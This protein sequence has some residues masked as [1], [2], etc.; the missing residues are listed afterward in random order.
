MQHLFIRKPV[1][2][3]LAL[4]LLS[5][6][7]QSTFAV[8]TQS[9]ATISNTATVDYQVGT[10]PRS[11]TGA[12][13]DILVDNRVDMTV[14][15]TDA[16]NN[17]NVNPGQ[18]DRVLTFT[19]TNTGNT[20]QGYLLSVDVPS[21]AIPMGNIRIYV[22]ANNDGIPDAGELYTAGTN[23]GDL[24]PN[25]VLGTD[26]VMQVLVVAD[27]PAGALD[28]AVDDVRL[29]AQATN[30]GTATATTA[31][32]TPTA[33]VDVVFADAAGT[34]SDANRDG[35]HSAAASYTVLSAALTAAK[36][37]LSTTDEFGSGFA[38]PGANVVYQIRV[39]NGGAATVDANTVA[40]MDQ[41]PAS[42]RLCVATVGNCTAPAF[43]D[44]TPSSG[45]SVAAFEYSFVSGPT[46]CDNASF[47]GSTPTAD[48]DG[49]DA[50]VTC[51]RQRPTGS[52]SGS[53]GFFDV[54]ITVGIQ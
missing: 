42:T 36:T 17:V 24:N 25:G 53:G 44:G 26:D 41:I 52:M 3:L 7:A 39:T 4:A 43:V 45:L 30:A 11:A 20:T 12:A 47:T 15:N 34:T 2:R 32:V 28:A 51:V 27:T 33:G 38:I 29:V 18:V 54:R 50:T 13:P 46:A 9:G 48:A 19:V 31:A 35:Q 37:V 1:S 49:Y 22:D 10:D 23:A 6:G 40:V 5:A 16:G 14:T 8:G 21:A